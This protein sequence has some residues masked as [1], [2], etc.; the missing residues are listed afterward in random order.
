LSGSSVPSTLAAE[1]SSLLHRHYGITGNAALLAGEKDHNFLVT[2]D[3]GERFVLKI[4]HPEEQMEV[5]R[6]Q[7]EALI[8]MGAVDPGLFIPAVI[9][10]IDGAHEFQA[11]MSDGSARIMRLLS[12][13]EGTMLHET[14]ASP[15]QD[16]ALG[17]FLAR[18]G[19]ALRDFVQPDPRT[20]HVW[21]LQHLPGTRAMTSHI[22]DPDLR[23]RV[24]LAY[25]DFE[26]HVGGAL[27][28]LRTQAVHNDMNPYN[29]VADPRDPCVVKGIIDFGDMAHAP[30]A[31]DA[32]IGAAYRWS[33]NEHPLAG[34]A[35]F[36]QGYTQ[37]RMLLEP[38]LDV[39]PDLIRGRLAMTINV[40]N[41]QA[42]HA[43]DNRGYALR[44]QRE[45]T[46]ALGHLA[47]VAR[48]DGRQWL[49]KAVEERP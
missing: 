8:H 12:Y 20:D 18:V 19:L 24:E 30:L 35:R 36:L 4:S 7:R 48:E 3:D 9:R 2:T 34:A 37:I 44:L 17:A 46:Q 21:D 6:F 23:C 32:A 25:D 29:V 49:R 38:E 13:L 27:A 28:S 39:M 26:R 22:A 47:P 31:C 41:W 10:A 45:L 15:R 11:E 16:R 14:A 40:A 43:P 42:L 5:V 1:V 33:L